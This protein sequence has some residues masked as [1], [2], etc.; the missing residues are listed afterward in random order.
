M[1]SSVGCLH[2]NCH[3]LGYKTW[4]W[5]FITWMCLLRAFP[6][7]LNQQ[8]SGTQTVTLILKSYM[9]F[10]TV[11]CHCR[12]SRLLT[13]KYQ[14]VKNF[15][16]VTRFK[17]LKMKIKNRR[18]ELTQTEPTQLH[19]T[20]PN[21]T[22]PNPSQPNSYQRYIHPN[23]TTII[24]GFIHPNKNFQFFQIFIFQMLSLI[25]PRVA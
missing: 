20:Q 13:N 2:S 21:L 3:L 4:C 1:V 12:K 16:L 11:E 22:W 25:S 24:K 9:L 17:I 5:H 15:T 7:Q 14:G 8:T 19:P 6:F 18:P 10:C 23:W